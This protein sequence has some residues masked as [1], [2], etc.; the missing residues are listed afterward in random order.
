MVEFSEF[1]LQR[2]ENLLREN[3]MYI[4][5][6]SGHIAKPRPIL[7]NGDVNIVSFEK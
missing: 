2:V 1:H 6:P 7:E 3:Q 5:P 4:V